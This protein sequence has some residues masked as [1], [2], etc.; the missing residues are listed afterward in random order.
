MNKIIREDIESIIE[1]SCVDWKVFKNKTVLITGAN[2]MLPS[3]MALTFLRLNQRFDLNIKLIC[4]VRNKAKA[5]IVFSDFLSDKN[6]EFIVQDVS[7]PIVYDGDLHYIV[8]AASQASPKYYGID[9][10]GTAKANVIGTYN[11][12]E[13]AKTKKVKSFLFFSSSGVYGKL[14]SEDIVLTENMNGSVD[15]MN[16]RSSYFESKRMAEN[17]CVCYNYQYDVPVKIVRI[18][19][20]LG[21][22]MDLTDGRAFSDICSSIVEGRDIVLKSKGDALRTF[23]YV[24]DAVIAFFMILIKGI[25]G[26]AYN[27]GSSTQEVSIRN[28]AFA[29]CDKYSDKRYKVIFD[30]DNNDITYASMRNPID[31]ILPDT[32]K[33]EDL[34]WTESVDY[35]MAFDRVIQSKLMDL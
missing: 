29:L 5:D 24:T 28:L 31:R 19:H 35:L 20:T 8:H 1:S 16:V 18:F 22:N 27:V 15:Q 3:Y 25:N 2:G 26:E 4:L 13:L 17:I 14:P 10:V 23:C 6:L 11:L 9:P 33:L 7:S 34:G 12:L 32:S 30:I 21:P